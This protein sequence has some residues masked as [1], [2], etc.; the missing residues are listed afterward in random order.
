MKRDPILSAF[1]SRQLDEGMALAAASDR[2]ELHVGRGDPPDRFLARFRCRGLVRTRTGEIVE[3]DDWQVGIW[4]PPE[5][6]TGPVEPFEVVSWLWP[7]TVFHPN[8]RAPFICVGRVNPGTPLV[9]L[10]Y[11][12]Y[13]IVS[14]QRVTPREDDALDLKACVWAREQRA[15]GRFPIDPRPLKRPAVAA[16]IP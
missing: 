2:L 12:I 11:Q 13:E 9:D 5:Y 4:F 7:V 6:L 8:I 10:L 15:L 14:Y 1:L 16:V 3:H